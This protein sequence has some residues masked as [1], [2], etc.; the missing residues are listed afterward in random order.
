MPAPGTGPRSASGSQL[1]S[2][3]EALNFKCILFFPIN[4]FYPL[5][6][7][8]S[9]ECKHAHLRQLVL[10]PTLHSLF[11]HTRKQLHRCQKHPAVLGITLCSLSTQVLG[12]PGVSDGKESACNEG[13]PASISGLGRTPGGGNGNLLQYSRLENLHG[14][15]SLAGYR[16]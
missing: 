1:H 13:D 4:P 8:V 7:L 16:P 12:F 3:Q 5:L 6:A 11:K 2:V 15:R 14:Q 9:D 10:A